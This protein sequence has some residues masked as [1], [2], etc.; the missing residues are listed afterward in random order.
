MGADLTMAVMKVFVNPT[1]GAAKLTDFSPISLCNT[2]YKTISKIIGTQLKLITPLVVQQYQ[3][4]FVIQRLLCENV[5]FA[6]DHVVDFH[7]KGHVSRVCLQIN[8]T[9]G[10]ENVHWEFI[11]K[12]VMPSSFLV[13]HPLDSCQHHLTSLFSLLKW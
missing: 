12:F 9:K 13:F 2:F 6:S 10:Y 8:I 11:L 1:S 4:E 5:L 7:K 3:V